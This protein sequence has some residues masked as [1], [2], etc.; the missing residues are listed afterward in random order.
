MKEGKLFAALERV[1]AGHGLP[2]P[3]KTGLGLS[4]DQIDNL[5]NLVNVAIE[6][7]KV[8]LVAEVVK[9]KENSAAT[10]GE[11]GSGQRIA[12]RDAVSII[13]RSEYR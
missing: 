2:H 3:A 12:Y 4:Y 1:A 7:F 11:F 10:S 13:Q 6:E 8:Q 5:D 9:S